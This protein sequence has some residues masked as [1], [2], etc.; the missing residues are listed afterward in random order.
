MTIRRKQSGVATSLSVARS[1]VAGNRERA[2]RSTAYAEAVAK[3]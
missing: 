2:M 1:R 3:R